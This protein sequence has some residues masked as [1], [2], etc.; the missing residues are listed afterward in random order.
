VPIEQLIDK[1]DIVEIVRDEIAAMLLL[2]E[3]SQRALATAAGK[4]PQRWAFAVF[5]GLSSAMYLVN[6]LADLEDVRRHPIKSRRPIASGEVSTRTAT[7]GAALLGGGA[8]ALAFR[9]EA[10]LGWVAASFTALLATYTRTLKH[11]VL[12]D[13]LAIAAGFVIRAVA[14][15]VAV[16]VPISQWLLVCTILL[17]LFLALSKRRYEVA[18]LGD[19]ASGH[20]RALAHYSPAFLDQL[21]TIVAGACVVA[22]ALYTA[23]PATV[24]N[25]GT[26]R[27]T[28]T[29][30]FP[31]YG[32]FRYLYLVHTRDGGG[33]PTELLLRDRPLLVCVALWAL[34][35]IVV[36]YRPWTP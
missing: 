19:G 31:I 20:R 33:D 36:I 34:T 14:G 18:L 6:D 10:S 30:P 7:L 17:A 11:I 13:V 22:Y 1:Q 5:C 23:E 8:L 26:E 4:D 12:L 29:L 2:E 3:S 27:L 35:I 24:R 16:E 9:L 32:I 25:F 21:I 15:A 28:W